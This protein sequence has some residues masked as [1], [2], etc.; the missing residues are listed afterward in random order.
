[1]IRAA[2]HSTRGAA[3]STRNISD[4]P[5]LPRPAWPLEPPRARVADLDRSLEFYMRL[6]CEVRSAA[7]GWVLLG[8]GPTT[9]VLIPHTVAPP[10][11][12]ARQAPHPAPPPGTTDQWIRL[13]TPDVRALRW[14]LLTEGVPVGPVITTTV[15]TPT[16]T[17]TATAV[18]T[19]TIA[20]IEVNDPDRLSPTRPPPARPIPDRDRPEATSC[21]STHTL[22]TRRYELRS[23][24]ARNQAATPRTNPL[25]VLA[26]RGSIPGRRCRA[27][28]PSG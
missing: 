27:P 18:A 4:K 19:A 28:R 26:P 21:R 1:M 23:S 16:P 11:P 22:G 14:R 20:E 25:V 7:D 3:R 15:A 10:D 24:R 6:G 13:T 9:F 2:P 8:F 5:D 12:Q 17:A